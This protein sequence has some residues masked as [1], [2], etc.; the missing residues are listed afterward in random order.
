MW[1]SRPA[2]PPGDINLLN[3]KEVIVSTAIKKAMAYATLVMAALLSVGGYAAAAEQTGTGQPYPWQLGLQAAASPVMERITDFHNLLLVII[4]AIAAFVLLLLLIIIFR[5]NSKANPTPSKTSHNT[6]LEV[7]WTLAPVLI[8]VFI[9]VPSLKLLYFQDKAENADMTIKAIGSQ[10]YWSY[11]YPDHG[12]IAFDSIMLS[13]EEAAAAGAPRTL[14]TD[15][16]LVVP[17][18]KSVRLLVTANDVI[19]SWAIPAFGVKIDAVPGRMNETWFR[20]DKEGLYYGQCS[21]LCGIKHAFMPIVVEV[22]SEERFA[23]WVEEAK[24]E[25]GFNDNSAAPTQI[26]AAVQ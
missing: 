21:E 14:A 12:D 6:L 20:A 7:V 26:A 1:E 8:L 18:G 4:T 19:H 10:W 15:T 5:F 16:H 17:V 24:A 9:A 23:Q 13:D 25:Y 11:E 3:N 2:N 22:V